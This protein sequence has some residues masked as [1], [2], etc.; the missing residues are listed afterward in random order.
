MSHISK[1]LIEKSAKCTSIWVQF[2]VRL[3]LDK[4]KGAIPQLGRR[5]GV[6]LPSLGLWARRWINHLSPWRMASA[7]PDLRLPSQPQGITALWP[8]PNYTAW[9]QRHMCVNNLP[10]VVTWQCP[11]AESNLCPWMTSGLQVRHITVRLPSRTATEWFLSGWM[12]VSRQH[13][14]HQD[15]LSLQSLRGR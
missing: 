3:L 13:H 6:H 15:Q 1:I 4:S 12:T 14:Q 7:M 2:Q 5:R 11:D 9:W 8:V 10:K